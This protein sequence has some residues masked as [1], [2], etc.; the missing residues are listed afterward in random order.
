MVDNLQLQLY[1]AV[2]NNDLKLV[3]RLVNN[4]ANPAGDHNFAI[5]CASGN[6]NFEIVKYLAGLA[7]VDPTAENNNAL[8][9]AAKNGHLKIV[10]LLS[11]LP[12]VKE[13][14]GFSADIEYL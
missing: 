4:G 14:F 11:Q 7:A 10:V 12:K 2:R 8:F 1:D 13:C 3:E 5:R 6:N 9:Q